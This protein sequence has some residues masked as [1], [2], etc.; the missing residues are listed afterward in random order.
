MTNVYVGSPCLG[1]DLWS[2]ENPGTRV[3]TRHR[4]YVKSVHDTPKRSHFKLAF[5]R[6][7]GVGLGLCCNLSDPRTGG[8]RNWRRVIV[9]TVIVALVRSWLRVPDQNKNKDKDRDN[10]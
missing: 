4:V 9:N 3:S 8:I 6:N 10:A 7:P 5:L 1:S 2:D